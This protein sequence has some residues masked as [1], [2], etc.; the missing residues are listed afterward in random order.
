MQHH[1]SRN[2]KQT[3]HMTV[4]IVGLL[5]SRLPARNACYSLKSNDIMT[6]PAGNVKRFCRRNMRKIRTGTLP[7]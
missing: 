4:E 2:L 1:E 7:A 5:R 3:R 6:K